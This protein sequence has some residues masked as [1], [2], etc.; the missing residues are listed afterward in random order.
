ML[1]LKLAEK[2]CPE[3]IPFSVGGRLGDGADGEVFDIVGRPDRVVKFGVIYES[4]SK[5]LEQEYKS[6]DRVLGYLISNPAPVYAQVFQHALMGT[7][8][9]EAWKSKCQRYV[10]YYYVMEKLNKISEDEK[11]VFHTIM[12]HE[13]AR[14]EKKFSDTQFKEILRGLSKGL[15]F[16]SKK[17][18]FFY[19][20]VKKSPVKHLD[21][22]PRNIMKDASGNFKLIDFDRADL[23]KGE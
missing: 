20:N 12:S 1:V 11:K 17:I 18:T 14:K 8:T 9:R 10:M 6:V 15:D 22:H 5:S 2:L 4:G 19:Q 23:I 7:F 13:D 16:D 21:I 3:R